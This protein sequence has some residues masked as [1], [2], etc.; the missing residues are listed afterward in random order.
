[1]TFEFLIFYQEK[2]GIDICIVLFE[3]LSQVTDEL[4]IYFDDFDSDEVKEL[5]IFRHKRLG[6]ETIDQDGNTL[7]NTI[8]GFAIELPEDTDEAQALVERFSQALAEADIISHIVKFEDPLLCNNLIEW[9]K[10][11]FSLEMK[12]R[13]VL[14]L[15][16]LNAYQGDFYNLLREESVK[17]MAPPTAEDMQNAREN[18]FFH[19]TFS[20]YVQLNNRPDPQ[21][22]DLLL[23]I[24]STESYDF[25]YAELNRKPVQD[26]N[27]AALL[28]D[29]KDKMG[30]IEKM[31]NCVAHNRQPSRRTIGSYELAYREI[32]TL[33]DSYLNQWGW[34]ESVEGE[35]LR[36]NED[37]FSSQVSEV[38]DA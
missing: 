8:L 16:Y 12:L 6:D 17:C 18:H 33:L 19:L 24:R 32:D 23:N 28:L 25:L 20:Q 15:I 2:I 11:I 35:S 38:Q 5:L 9:S 14:S 22:R 7:R 31:R 10:K 29:L 3:L 4:E 34:Q 21:L 30:A 1:M 26:L 36:D 13:R 27:D 37:E